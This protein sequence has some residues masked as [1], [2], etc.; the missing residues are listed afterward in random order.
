M[1]TRP[2]HSVH[3]HLFVELKGERWLL[4][5]GAPTS[6]G[7]R[8]P[9]TFGEES[10]EIAAEFMGLTPA[11]LSGYTDVSCA[12][13]IGVD[14][15]NRFD[16]RFDLPGETLTL[17]REQLDNGGEALPLT[18][19]IGIPIVEVQI[20][21]RTFPMFLDTGA[22]VS[23]LQDDLLTSFP[24]AGTVTDFYPGLGEFETE[25]YL[26]TASIGSIEETL[27][28]GM[29]PPLLSTTLMIAGA[30]GIVGNTLFH[31]RQVTYQPRRHQLVLGERVQ[32]EPRGSAKPE[33]Y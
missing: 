8:S 26:V 27:H 23:Y 17:T 4:D 28:C 1:E 18:E 31:G 16:L 12:G 15:L 9:L 5:T 25:T 11:K 3:D 21:G 19:A 7:N 14:L 6:F 13:L 30:S 24:P 2:L 29:L 20:G 22:P 32:Q 33:S 10:F